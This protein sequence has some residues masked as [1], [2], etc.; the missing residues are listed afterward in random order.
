M[1]QLF[2]F[3]KALPNSSGKLKRKVLDRMVEV[4]RRMIDAAGDRVEHNFS[5]EELLGFLEIVELFG[6]SEREKNFIKHKIIRFLIPLGEIL[7]DKRLAL[8]ILPHYPLIS[9]ICSDRLKDDD[10]FGRAVIQI[11]KMAFYGLSKR[12]MRSREMNIK[13]F[14][15]LSYFIHGPR[16]PEAFENRKK[17]LKVV[18]VALVGAIKSHQCNAVTLS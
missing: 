1:K 13:A 4:C 17:I 18:F 11:N 5:R 8:A 16:E 3:Y 6:I 12:L 14:G 15:R 9:F 2:Y 7:D 10:E